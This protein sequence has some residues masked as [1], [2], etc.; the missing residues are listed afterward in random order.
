LVSINNVKHSRGNTVQG[1]DST[2]AMK[3]GLDAALRATG[4]VIWFSFIIF[5]VGLNESHGLCCADDAWFAI[6]AKSLASGLGY[7][8]TFATFKDAVHPVLFNPYTGTGPTLIVPCA[9]A[10]KIFGKNEVLPG[11]TAIFI[12]GSLLTFVLVRMSRRVNGL[13]FL[14]GVSGVCAAFVATFSFHFGQWYAFL[15]EIVAAAFLILAHWIITNER[16]SEKASFLCGLAV[17]C[18]VQAKLLAALSAT[19]IILIFVVRGTC[20]GLRPVCLVKHATALLIAFLI[21]TLAFEAY[22]LFEL[23]RDGYLANWQEL[24][25]YTKA[26]GIQSNTHVNLLLLRQRIAVVHDRFGVTVIG[27]LALIA[28]GVLLYWR[29]SS[30]N[31]I[32]LSVGLLFSIA[33]TA[34]YWATLSTGWPRYL[35]I[36]VALGVFLLSLPIFT[37]ELRP[38]LVFA[39]LTLILLR[40]GISRVGFVVH[41]ADHG[42]FRP[43]TERTARALLVRAIQQRRQELPATILAS[44]WWGSFAD[45]EFMLPGSMNFKRIETVSELPQPKIILLNHR[46]DPPH[47]ELIDKMKARTSSIIFAGGPYELLEV[48]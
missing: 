43:T 28:F 24:I 37:L 38:K 1:S 40:T 48:R 47:D 29:S 5:C 15:G 32:L 41:S 39:L 14:L 35:I 26:Q 21:P 16:F 18:A 44:R 8:T 23:G 17:G 13:S 11:L 22:K 34:I 42:L 7:A 36:A 20:A 3:E 6:M 19:G 31:W 9:I 33:T 46:F 12:W 2:I 4:F 10:F 25:N 30:E 45:V 27:V